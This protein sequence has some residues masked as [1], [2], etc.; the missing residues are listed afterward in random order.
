VDV[1]GTTQQAVSNKGYLADNAAKVTITLPAS[2]TLGDVIQVVGIGA[3]GWKIAQNAGQ[4]TITTN[5]MGATTYPWTVRATPRTVTP[6]SWESVASSSDGTHLVAAAY[7]GQLYTSA[8]SGVTWTARATSQKWTSVASSVDGTHLV[9]AVNAGQIYTSTDSGVNWTARA[10]VQNWFSVASSSDGTHLVAVVAA[11]QIYTSTDSGVNWTARATVQNWKSV[12]SSSDGTHLVAVA[13]VA[14]TSGF[15]EDGLIY[16]STDSGVHWKSLFW[17]RLYLSSVASSSD[18]TH[19]VAAGSTGNLYT[20]ADSGA[21]WAEHTTVQSSISPI[22]A[23][24]V[25]SSTD[26]AHL[27]AVGSSSIYTSADSGATWTEISWQTSASVGS[28]ISPSAEDFRSVASS[29]DGIHLVAVS[30]AG[31]VKN[32]GAGQIYTSN[33]FTTTSGTTGSISGSQ[34][35]AIELQYIGNNTFTVLNYAGSLIVQ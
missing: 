12:A 11:D 5:I 13:D 20:S 9:A 4:S 18:G 1:T 3:G 15:V 32:L 34:Y 21:T 22:S 27:V 29:S 24:S 7:N 10:T 35:D 17:S 26:G 8:N 19:L 16:T 23:V 28:G 31:G 2:P 25:A 6:Q 30:F 14:P 33:G